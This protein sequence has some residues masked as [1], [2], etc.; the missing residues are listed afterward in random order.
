M[1]LSI[2]S[3]PLLALSADSYPQ[4]MNDSPVSNEQLIDYRLLVDQVG[5]HNQ[6]SFSANDADPNATP[7]VNTLVIRR[8][9]LAD[10]PSPSQA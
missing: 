6:P 4:A 9:S 8:N 5:R 3:A 1:D 2:A 7:W 10:T